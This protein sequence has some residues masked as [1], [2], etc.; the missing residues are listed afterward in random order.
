MRTGDPEI[1]QSGLEL[2]DYGHPHRLPFKVAGGFHDDRGGFLD[3][4]R[5]DMAVEYGMSKS[6]AQ[7]IQRFTVCAGCGGAP[8]PVEAHAQCKLEVYRV[9]AVYPGGER[10]IADSYDTICRVAFARELDRAISFEEVDR[11]ISNEVSGDY[12]R[13]N[14]FLRKRRLS[15]LTTLERARQRQELFARHEGHC[16]YCFAPIEPNADSADFDHFVPIALGGTGDVWNL[17]AACKACNHDKW[18]IP[19][20]EFRA[21]VRRRLDNATR[22]A[23]V[24]LQARVD[25]WREQ[26]LE[27]YRMA[28][29]RRD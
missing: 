20:P 26:K 28:P 14:K 8:F 3:I 10:E 16:Y 29:T 23:V 19:G 7:C 6:L 27:E 21:A 2:P 25:E 22:R 11:V 4:V 1:P 9:V 24:A 15:K 18:T 5:V 12:K 17:V 13:A